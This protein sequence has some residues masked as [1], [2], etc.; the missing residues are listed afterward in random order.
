METEATGF[1]SPSGKELHTSNPYRDFEQS[2]RDRG[3]PD[4]CSPVEKFVDE[5]FSTSME[6]MHS[7]FTSNQ[8]GE[9]FTSNRKGE[10]S[11]S[12]N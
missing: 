8:K 10:C 3:T 11:N 5:T 1:N 4:S 9:C 2:I 6:S 7:V 12:H